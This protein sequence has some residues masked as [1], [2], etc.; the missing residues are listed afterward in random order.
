MRK[1][2]GVVFAVAMLLPIGLAASPAGAAGGTTCKPP[3]G[4]LTFSPGVGTT[5]KVQTIAIN[6]PITGCSGGGVTGGTFKGT[7][8]TNPVNLANLQKTASSLKLTTTITWNTK[9]TSTFT[10]STVTKIGKTIVSTVSGKIT[11]GLFVGLTFKSVQTVTFGPVVGGVIK[12]LN[13][14]GSGPITIK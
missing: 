13:I 5:L 2:A 10:A 3:S 1:V 4:K 14:K 6:L 8:K 12:T 11:K 9:A 7:L